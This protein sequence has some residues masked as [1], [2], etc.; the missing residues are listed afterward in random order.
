MDQELLD[1]LII[2]KLSGTISTDDQRL[3]ERFLAENQEASQK[4]DQYT[5]LWNATGKVTAP[6]GLSRD[7]RWQTLQ[8]KISTV[9][10]EKNNARQLS[11]PRYA[12]VL[13][14]FAALI[15][16]YNI[17]PQRNLK[18]ITTAT[19][20]SKTITLPD[21]SVVKLN[22]ETTISYDE[23]LWNEE[24]KIELK[25]EAYFEVQKNGSP[26]I[27]VSN[28]AIVKVLGTTF[29]VKSRAD[30]TW[31][32][33]FS[34]KV[35]VGLNDK[36]NRKHILTAG[37]GAVLDGV[38]LSEVYRISNNDAKGWIKGELYFQD[39]PLKEV[40][41]E[42]ERHFNKSIRVEKDVSQHSFTGRFKGNDF[43][44]ALKTICL[45]AGLKFTINND[46][47]VTVE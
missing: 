1:T 3:L 18:T 47:T 20:E 30:R 45:S 12:A 46:S 8:K 24:R 21:H 17:L 28:K 35:S 43:E 22:S 4:Y 39:T 5:K 40:F 38:Q 32:L 6:T 14:V 15:F 29:N 11:W 9:S 33:C 34:G 2:K 23:S 27:V 19:S 42:L 44:G 41:A 25:G 16:V 10:P 13:A 36:E 7:I 31:V 37:T 26:F